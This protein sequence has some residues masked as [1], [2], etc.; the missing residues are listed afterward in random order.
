M[1]RSYFM[2]LMMIV[3]I[4]GSRGRGPQFSKKNCWACLNVERN[5]SLISYACIIEINEE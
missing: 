4:I 1:K 5:P 2:K 3:G